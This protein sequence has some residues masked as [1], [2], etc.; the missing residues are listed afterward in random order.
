[1]PHSTI[2]DEILA[3]LGRLSPEAREQVAGLVRALAKDQRA[4][5]KGEQLLP[6]SGTVEEEDL[7]AMARAIEQDCEQVDRSA[8]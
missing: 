3:I 2:E 5:T 1:M 6:F 8:W 4:G 7:Q